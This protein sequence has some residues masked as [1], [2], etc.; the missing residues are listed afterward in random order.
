MLILRHELSSFFI[1]YVDAYKLN[2][3]IK[4]EHVVFLFFGI[5]KQQAKEESL[6]YDNRLFQSCSFSTFK[7]LLSA[8][9]PHWFVPFYTHYMDHISWNMN[10]EENE[11]NN[12]INC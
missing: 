11:F 9:P 7:F 5:I 10:L 6:Q 8:H 3:T 2:T 1:V 12:L 4:S